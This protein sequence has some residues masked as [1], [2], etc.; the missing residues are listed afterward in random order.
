[1]Y[2]RVPAQR[3]VP[4]RHAYPHVHTTVYIPMCICRYLYYL[5]VR[6]GLRARASTRGYLCGARCGRLR[7]L[8]RR[9]ASPRA[10]P[11]LHPLLLR[12]CAARGAL[13]ASVRRCWG[14][15]PASEALRGVLSASEGL[16][17][18]QWAL[19]ASAALRPS[20]WLRRL[21]GLLR[22]PRPLLAGR[23]ERLPSS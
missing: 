11:P 15:S 14:A 1:M 6:M 23:P 5:P 19:G 4:T 2:V 20:E 13:C 3:G 9:V 22:L 12:G 7:L 21:L 17:A 18:S 8:P 16:R 10:V